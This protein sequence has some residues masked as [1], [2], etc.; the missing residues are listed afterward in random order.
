MTMPLLTPLSLKGGIEGAA[1]AFLASL[2]RP[3]TA[4]HVF[5]YTFDWVWTVTQQGTV[6]GLTSGMA[7]GIYLDL[8]F[9]F[10]FFCFSSKARLALLLALFLSSCNT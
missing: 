3:S 9:S 5:Q 10:V 6:D 8:F 2:D 7:I 1:E 4:K